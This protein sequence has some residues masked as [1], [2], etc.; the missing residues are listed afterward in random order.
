MARFYIPLRNT[1]VVGDVYSITFCLFT[2][3]YA[4]GARLVE[5]SVRATVKHLL[6]QHL[7]DGIVGD[8]DYSAVLADTQA[9]TAGLVLLSKLS[10]GQVQVPFLLLAHLVYR[11][12][13]AHYR[14]PCWTCTAER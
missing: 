13:T 11:E 3:A 12:R 8:A 1:V 4:P 14:Q 6:G 7:L 9:H 2:S 10:G 5:R